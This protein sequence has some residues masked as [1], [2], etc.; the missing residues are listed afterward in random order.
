M[1][2][3]VDVV[4]VCDVFVLLSGQ[5]TTEVLLGGSIPDHATE[6]QYVRVCLQRKALSECTRF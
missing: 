6:N 4:V 3:V 5:A 2:V 1:P